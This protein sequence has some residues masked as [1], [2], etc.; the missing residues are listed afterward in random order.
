MENIQTPTKFTQEIKDKW[1]EA[2]K[3]GKYIQ[4]YAELVY[5]DESEI[6]RH[7]CLGVLGEIIEGITND[8]DKCSLPNPYSFLTNTIGQDLKENLYKTND[9]MSND[10]TIPL[11]YKH[12][13]SNVIP[14]I[15]ALEVQE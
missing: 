2:L 12:D 3:S 14:L 15:E 1:L 7:C 10:G 9:K 4:G 13:Y 6:K 11:D 5:I 8:M